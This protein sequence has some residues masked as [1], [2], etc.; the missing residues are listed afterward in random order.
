MPAQDMIIIAQNL[1]SHGVVGM[2]KV[3]KL[4]R[5]E[6]NDATTEFHATEYIIAARNHFGMSREEAENLTMTEFAMLINAR[7]PDQKGF[8]REEF[9][10]VMDEDERRWQAMMMKERP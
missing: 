3:R 8:T 1:M 5:Y 10:A 2:A 9:D 4:Q 6:S 7:Y